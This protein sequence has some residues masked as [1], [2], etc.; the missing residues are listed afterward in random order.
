MVLPPLG[1]KGLGSSK[2]QI[3][4]N[5]DTSGMLREVQ[6]LSQ[7][8]RQLFYFP[9]SVLREQIMIFVSCQGLMNMPQFW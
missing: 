7:T 4:P 3:A 2:C 9:E 8:S 6:Q 1:S 5:T